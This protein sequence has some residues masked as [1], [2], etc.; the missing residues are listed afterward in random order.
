MRSHLKLSFILAAAIFPTLLIAADPVVL[1][2]TTE[3]RLL[4][5]EEAK[6]A[7]HEFAVVKED[8]GKMAALYGTTSKECMNAFTVENDS[9]K[10]EF[11]ISF[12]KGS[13]PTCLD[14]S[15]LDVKEHESL[16]K[17]QGAK[18]VFTTSLTTVN[19]RSEDK[20]S[21]RR[22]DIFDELLDA[23]RNEKI[24]FV[25]DADNEKN[26]KS[27]AEK[28]A[29][30][31]VQKD[32]LLAT[33]CVHGLTEL[34]MRTTAIENLA[35]VKD[36]V[37]KDEIGDKWFSKMRK[38]TN[39]KIFSAC[40]LQVSRAKTY[41]LGLCDD[42]LAKLVAQDDTY[43]PK[44]R[45]LYMTLVNRYMNSSSLSV[46]EAF[47]KAE[48]MIETLRGMDLDEKESAALDVAERNLY[49][50]ML[51]KASVEGLESEAFTGMSDKF[52]AHLLDSDTLGCLD[53]D[54]RLLVTQRMNAGCREAA[55]MSA[56]LQKSASM[57]TAYAGIL[58]KKAELQF[59]QEQEQMKYSGCMEIKAA[60][61]IVTPECQA[62]ETK[63]SNAASAVA[64]QDIQTGAFGEIVKDSRNP[65]GTVIPSDA[66]ILKSAAGN[67]TSGLTN[68]PGSNQSVVPQQNV[69]NPAVKTTVNTTNSVRVYR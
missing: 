41:D 8:D 11:T 68:A 27:E 64:N 58:K 16:S 14:Y 3:D 62:L 55:W 34:D 7:F 38:E 31:D 67:N 47:D 59:A 53:G 10:G 60:G 1:V 45:A 21:D 28:Q 37:A 48:G 24:S 42:R 29:A 33:S 18:L 12:S 4:N 20:K 69:Q 61:G 44:V 25:S 46:A 35:N 39:E 2:Q 19:L 32:Y 43:G 52:K 5:L 26:K 65:A 13:D 40:K 15:K 6:R 22:P 56:Q 57:A 49:L 36:F 17:K 66:G 51:R 63:R 50:T 54:A 23:D 30:L 9:K